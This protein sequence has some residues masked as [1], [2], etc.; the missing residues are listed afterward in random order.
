VDGF[1]AFLDNGRRVRVDLVSQFISALERILLWFEEQR[2]YRF[3]SS[4]L[5]L[6]YEGDETPNPTTTEGNGHTVLEQQQQQAQALSGGGKR[7]IDVRIIDFAHA[8]RADEDGRA[9]EGFIHGLKR[10]IACFQQLLV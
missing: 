1:R 6:V 3:Y 9:D 4:S 10:A 2:H 7:V 8:T 5:L